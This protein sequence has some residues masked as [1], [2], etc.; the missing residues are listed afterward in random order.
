MRSSARKKR[1]TKVASNCSEHYRTVGRNGYSQADWTPKPCPAPT[2][3]WPGTPERV[4]LY[5]WRLH[6]GM[7]LH[8]Q[9]DAVFVDEVPIEDFEK[10]ILRR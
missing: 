8:H 7:E 6:L 3:I 1:K 10:K 5:A 4:E 2:K 9:D